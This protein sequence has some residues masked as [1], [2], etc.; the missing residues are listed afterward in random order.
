MPETCEVFKLER[1]FTD[2]ELKNLRFGHIPLEM[3]DKWFWYMEGN[4]FFA[5]RSGT[6][7][8]IYIVEIDAENTILNQYLPKT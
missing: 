5:Y 2:E 7:Y 4:N 6:G 1:K 8:C 3:E